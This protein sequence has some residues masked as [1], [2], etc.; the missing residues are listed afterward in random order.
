MNLTIGL[1]LAGVMAAGLMVASCGGGSETPNTQTVRATIVTAPA[2]LQLLCASEAAN[3]FGFEQTSVFATSSAQIEAA[4]YQVE[5]TTGPGTA[6]CV[7]EESGTIV[8]LVQV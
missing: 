2:D 5:L 7:V 8:S 4:R 6:T 3:R 1:R